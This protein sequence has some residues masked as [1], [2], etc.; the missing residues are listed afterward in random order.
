M[1]SR[2]EDLFIAKYSKSSILLQKIRIDLIYSLKEH[3]WET[4][5]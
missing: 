5:I 2:S 4:E 3:I 1:L